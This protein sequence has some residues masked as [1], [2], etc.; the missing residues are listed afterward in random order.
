MGE[1]SEC[2]QK[3]IEESLT[4]LL[5]CNTLDVVRLYSHR[6]SVTEASD[7]CLNALP[8][9]PH[10]YISNDS[11]DT[12]ALINCS[13]QKNLIVKLKAR[14]VLLKNLRLE[15]VNGLCGTI[16]S[17]VDDFPLVIFDNGQ[18]EL[19]REEL[20]TV[21]RDGN[22]VATR[23]QIPLDLAYAMTIHKSQGMSFPLLDVDLSS[24]FEAGQAYVAVS[25]AMTIDGLKISSY[26]QKMPQVC[27]LVV[28]FYANCVVMASNLN[29][30]EVFQSEK[31]RDVTTLPLI[32]ID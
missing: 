21:E 7:K 23:K 15:L 11:G 24:V 22:A 19:I 4:R 1:L 8:G 28:N 9:E 17:F 2:S 27:Q 10:H 5:D 31:K 16:H 13:A 32:N 30:D 6:D 25:R 14:V 20:F 26:R 18:R 12:K 29:V 3:F